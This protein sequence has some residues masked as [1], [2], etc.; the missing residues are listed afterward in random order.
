MNFRH[1]AIVLLSALPCGAEEDALPAAVVCGKDTVVLFGDTGSPDSHYALGWTIRPRTKDA[2][3]V[4]WSKY[5]EEEIGNADLDY[6][7]D[8]EEGQNPAYVLT[9]G[10]VDLIGKSFRELPLENPISSHHNHRYI[11][12]L[13]PGKQKA[14]VILDG[15]FWTSDLLLVHLNPNGPVINLMEKAA[16]EV[17]KVIA[18]KRPLASNMEV[19]YEGARTLT[20]SEGTIRLSFTAAHPKGSYEDF[21]GTLS[22]GAADGSPMRATSDVEADRP[23]VG[24]LGKEDERL[25]RVYRDLVKALDDERRKNLVSNQREWIT[26]R[27]SSAW[28]AGNE[29][30]RFENEGATPEAYIAARNQ[31]ALKLTRERADSL[32]KLLA[33]L[34]RH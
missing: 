8:D 13:W 26:T 17:A 29:K 33:T 28:Q 32:Q 1:L 4:D 30:S 23:F 16:P 34:T 21:C 18:A 20:A 10:V 6:P 3:P 25:N 2:S 5:K 19:I 14:I 9:D 7:W 22:F 27:D 12:A 15:R 31:E 24:E 11:E